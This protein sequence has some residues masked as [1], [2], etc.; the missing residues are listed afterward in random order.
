[1]TFSLLA[2]N[3][4]ALVHSPLTVSFLAAAGSCAPTVQP[5]SQLSSESVRILE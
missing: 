5:L 1:M 3:F 2:H 4:N